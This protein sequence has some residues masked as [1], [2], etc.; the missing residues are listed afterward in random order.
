MTDKN[1]EKIT[2]K[3]TT[4][5]NKSQSKITTGIQTKAF[6]YSITLMFSLLIIF[7][8]FIKLI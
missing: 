5:L 2:H 4:A 3:E 7:M 8:L 1:V 6:T